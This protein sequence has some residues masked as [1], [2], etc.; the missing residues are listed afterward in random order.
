VINK[1]GAPLDI[2][3]LSLSLSGVLADGSQIDLNLQPP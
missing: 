2:E 3:N 1:G